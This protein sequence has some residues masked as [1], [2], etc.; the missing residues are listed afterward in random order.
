MCGIHETEYFGQRGWRL[1]NKTLCAVFLP[2]QGGKV[3]SLRLRHSNFELLFQN[4]KPAFG[5]P[6]TGSAFHEF[7]ACGMDDAFPC[8][9]A[10]PVTVGGQTVAYPDHGEI[11]SAAFEATPL[12]DGL[13]LTYHS[14]LLGY[15][16]EKTFSLKGETLHCAYRI[17]NRSA[18]PFLYLWA[19][20]CLVRYEP[21]MRLVFPTGTRAVENVTASA[22]LGAPGTLY[23]FPSAAL[24]DGSVYDFA[25]VPPAQPHT[26]EKYYVHGRVTEGRCG[27]RYPSQGVAADILYDKAALPYLG[28][29]V[30][31]GA[32]RGDYNC[33]LEPATGYYDSIATARKNDACSV[34]EP[35]AAV[36]F[37]LAIRLYE[38]SGVS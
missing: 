4:P 25:S 35:G 33:A 5:T 26:M 11:W 38:K 21:D 16:Y 28:F 18:N 6:C 19:L 1:E 20:H 10:G 37:E 22:R 7:E 9:G 3:A 27:Y 14:P 8:I 29:W 34:L 17:E 32:F 24:P 23:P 13:R 36:S 31:A 15:L 30:T 12:A 2:R